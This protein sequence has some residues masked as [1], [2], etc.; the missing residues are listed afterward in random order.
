MQAPTHFY[1]RFDAFSKDSLASALVEF[2]KL[3]VMVTFGVIA[4]LG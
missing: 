3:Q 1:G 4:M 2:V